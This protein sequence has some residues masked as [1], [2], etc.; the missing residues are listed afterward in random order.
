MIL[1][2]KYPGYVNG[3]LFNLEKAYSTRTI[4]LDAPT[5]SEHKFR[6]NGSKSNRKLDA[7]G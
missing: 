3:K 7:N 1:L 4:K 2:Q 5:A 6:K